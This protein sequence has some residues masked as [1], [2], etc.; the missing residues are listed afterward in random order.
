M[1]GVG[2]GGRCGW[3][4]RWAWWQLP[5]V[6][7]GAEE[8]VEDGL[9]RHPLERQDRL[10]ALLVVVRP[11]TRQNNTSSRDSIRAVYDTTTRNVNTVLQHDTD[12]CATAI[13]AIAV[14]MGP[15]HTAPSVRCALELW[16][17]Y[18]YMYMYIRVNTADLLSG[19]VT[20]FT[21]TGIGKHVQVV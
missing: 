8:A 16:S 20:P 7:L 18:D 13:L 1:T 6:G 19:F 17:S 9:G 2:V 12:S 4:A 10:A 21:D 5:D 15:K 11:A 14:E 3:W